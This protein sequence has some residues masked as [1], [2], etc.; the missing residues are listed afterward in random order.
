MHLICGHYKRLQMMLRLED[1][2]L[3]MA[4]GLPGAALG[5]VGTAQEAVMEVEGISSLWVKDE[6]VDHSKGMMFDLK[7][8]RFVVNLQKR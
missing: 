4:E 7:Q 8:P 5:V 1:A 2:V 3:E 6:N